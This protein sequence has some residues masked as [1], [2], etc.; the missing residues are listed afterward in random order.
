M[1]DSTGQMGR[2]RGIARLLALCAVLLGLFL[3]HGS[4]AS[5][6]EGCHG[7]MSAPTA[8]S[9][10]HA[11]TAMASTPPAGMTHAAVQQTS[12]MSSMGG[13]MCLSTPPRDFTTLPVA[14][15]MAVVAVLAVLPVVGRP[16]ALGRTGRRGPPTPGGR[17]LLL[18]VCIART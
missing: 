6:A 16:V 2:R 4:P 17:S 5:S 9:A 3:M 8:L 11:G 7:A 12:A 1:T 10:K 18:Q 14:G 15:L 13:A